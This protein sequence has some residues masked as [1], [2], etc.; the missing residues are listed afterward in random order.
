MGDLIKDEESL[1]TEERKKLNSDY[2]PC[3]LF[4]EQNAL[5]GI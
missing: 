5:G 4:L 3:L 2:K 1:K